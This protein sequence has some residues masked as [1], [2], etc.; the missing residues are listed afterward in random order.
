[1]PESQD[2]GLKGLSGFRG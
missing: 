2:H 1:M